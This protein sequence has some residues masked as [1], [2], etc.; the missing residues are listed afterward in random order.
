MSF[1]LHRQ[2]VQESGPF[3]FE[4]HSVQKIV[5]RISICHMVI[6]KLLAIEIR[7]LGELTNN[8]P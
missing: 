3:S 5:A 1:L 2:S 8:R 7:C 4:R 6:G